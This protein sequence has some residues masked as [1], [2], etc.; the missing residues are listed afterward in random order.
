MSF[1]IALYLALRL[2]WQH[3]SPLSS[4]V[5]QQDSRQIVHRRE[6]AT[7]CEGRGD[8]GTNSA[9]LQTLSREKTATP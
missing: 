4:V 7:R 1:D 3:V 9:Q 6:I 5:P 8:V 2:Q